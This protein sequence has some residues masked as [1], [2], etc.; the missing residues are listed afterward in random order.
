MEK[1]CRAGQ[2]TDDNMAY[3]H[4]ILDAQGCKRTL[5]IGKTFFFTETVVARSSFNVALSVHC[6]SSAKPTLVPEDWHT[7]TLRNDGNYSL[8]DTVLHSRMRESWVALLW[9]PEVTYWSTACYLNSITSLAEWRICEV[10]Q[11]LN[12]RVFKLCVSTNLQRI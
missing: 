6:L 3:V 9:R 5:G 10:G 8:K 11:M 4:C 12:F 1:V 7:T 2:V